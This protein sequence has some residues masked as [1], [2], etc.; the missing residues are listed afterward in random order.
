MNITQEPNG[1]LQAII[2]IQIQEEDYK[3]KVNEVLKSYRKKANMPGF[4]PGMVPMGMI[5]KMYGA[6][7]MADEINKLVSEALDKYVYEQKLDILGHPLANMEKTKQIDFDKD[8]E[9]DFYFDIAL[10]PEFEVDLKAAGLE[11]PYYKIIPTDKEID[12]AVKDVQNRYGEEIH[13]DEV[14]EG[15]YVSGTFVQLDE[16][17]NELEGGY[18]K[19]AYFSVNDLKLKK[20]Q[21]EFIG[22]K[23]GDVVVV[24][25]E[26][27]F[28]K[29]KRAAVLGNEIT[30]EQLKSDYKF[31]I[32]E[33]TR[34]IPAELNEELFKKVY[35]D[36]ELKTEEDF[37]NRIKQDMEKEYAKESDRKFVD[38]TVKKLSEM[39][40]INLPDEFLKRWL[41]ESNQG[42]ITKEQLEVQYDN[43]AQTFK[44]QLIE[45]KLNK[46]FDNTLNVNTEEVRDQVRGYFGIR[47]KQS[48]NDQIE[49]IV[50]QVLSNP[51]EENRIYSNL[52][53]EKLAK[54][55]H[56]HVK[57]QEK[58]VTVD[59]FLKIL[60]ESQEEGKE[61]KKETEEKA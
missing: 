25:G 44:W 6:S 51:Q 60:S 56:E 46:Q 49:Q 33:I 29:D 18:A 5:K 39:I 54:V 59:E 40:D 16:N 52:K 30:D 20:Y 24:N 58:E 2:H 26:K 1:D 15:D 34:I 41:L 55:F 43:Y 50:D 32:K 53:T 28:D 45:S 4:R 38:D 13:P 12:T 35:P 11:I 3:D 10:A 27:A 42:Q 21:K 22:K 14:A 8:K 36:D 61:E 19:E 9:F 17:G 57:K 7:V 47:D 23:K 37:R 48:S 31:E